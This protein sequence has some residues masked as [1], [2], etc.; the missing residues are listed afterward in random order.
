MSIIDHLHGNNSF[1]ELKQSYV[2]NNTTYSTNSTMKL[3]HDRVNRVKLKIGSGTVA[4]T[5][6]LP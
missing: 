5:P 1:L 2:P 6:Y 4:G 3:L